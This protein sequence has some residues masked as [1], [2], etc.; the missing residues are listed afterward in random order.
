MKLRVFKIIVG[1]II[2][3]AVQF[4]CNCLVKTFNL[5]I[6]TPILGLIVFA[7]LLQ[8]KVIKQEWIEDVCN[9]LLKIMPLLFVPLFVGIIS[10]YGIIEK[11]LIPILVNIVLTTTLVLILTA[12]FV[13]NVIKFV[14]LHKMRK[15]KNE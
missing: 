7:F 1:F 3:C 2:I 13:D 12:L 8:I 9:F 14:R 11:N 15:S 5:I 6:P 4:I 10:Y